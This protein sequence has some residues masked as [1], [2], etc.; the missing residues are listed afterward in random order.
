MAVGTQ[1][2][3]ISQGNYAVAL[4]YL[5]GA[6]NQPANSIVINASGSGLDG[7][8]AGFYVNPVRNI[9]GTSIL[10]YNATTDEITHSN[11]ISSEEDISIRI[12]LSDSTQRVWRFGEDGILTL[13]AGGDIQDSTGTSVLGG[14]GSGSVLE[15]PFENKTSATGVIEHDATTNRLFRH[16]SISANFTANFTNL[17]LAVNEAT[18]ISLV[19]VQGA[20]A[21]MVTAVQIGGAAQ[22]ITWQGSASAPLGNANRTDVVTFSILCTAT[23]TYTVLGMLTSF[24]G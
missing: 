6:N 20:T 5:A 23:D 7:S 9:T 19:L 24:G 12:N 18:S 11:E 13:P 2:G 17:G 16:T 8:A 1:A 14:G 15:E 4:G 21:R 22:T 3:I 10:Q